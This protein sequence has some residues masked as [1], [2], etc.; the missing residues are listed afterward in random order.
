MHVY[1]HYQ[2]QFFRAS[3]SKK[4]L[5]PHVESG[6]VMEIRVHADGI[7]VLQRRSRLGD[8]C[9]PYSNYWNYDDKTLLESISHEKCRPPY[10]NAT[11]GSELC[12]TKQELRGLAMQVWNRY[13]GN[14]NATPPCRELKQILV[15]YDY[16]DTERTD[17]SF[18]NLR[19]MFLNP[20]FKEIK[21]IQAYSFGNF[22]SDVGGY[23]GLFLGYALVQIPEFV[24]MMYKDSKKLF[25]KMNAVFRCIDENADVPN[26]GRVSQYQERNGT[27]TETNVNEKPITM[28]DVQKQLDIIH[29][30]IHKIEQNPR[31]SNLGVTNNYTG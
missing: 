1:Y 27:T 19:V 31:Q 26:E 12:E 4:I 21:E 24:Y 9:S 5:W 2:K 18:Y 23:L 30:K 3:F 15:E 7:E 6:K 17:G 13:H 8:E 10:W 25:R 20:T 28:E 16:K 29:N 22:V 14:L 11:F